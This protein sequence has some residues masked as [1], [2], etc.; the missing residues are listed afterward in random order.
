MEGEATEEP[1]RMA[2]RAPECRAIGQH[3][4][5]IKAIIKARR[6]AGEQITV[7]RWSA[8]GAVINRRDRAPA[9]VQP[10]PCVPS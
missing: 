9:S 6:K 3:W 1:E 5:N 7:A 8:V 4:S 10:S 2:D